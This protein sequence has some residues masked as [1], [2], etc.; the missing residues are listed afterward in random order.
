MI[1]YQKDGISSVP[2]WTLQN[3]NELNQN[4]RQKGIWVQNWF[5]KWDESKSFGA[6]MNEFNFCD[7]RS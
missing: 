3:L 1:E 2:S 6:S 7:L 4:M 5:L